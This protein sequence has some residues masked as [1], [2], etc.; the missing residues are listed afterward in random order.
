[1]ALAVGCG[2]TFGP[3]IVPP[4]GVTLHTMAID[5]MENATMEP[6]LGATL[7]QR[8]KGQFLASGR[9]RIVNHNQKPEALLTGRIVSLTQ[10]PVAFD[11]DSRAIEYRLEIHV[12]L[13]L[14]RRA[15]EAE[16]WSASGLLGYA[17][18][19]VNQD[20]ELS[21]ESKERALDDASQQIADAVTQ[22]FRPSLFETASPP[23]PPTTPPPTAPI[24]APAPSPASPPKSPPASK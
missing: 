13:A 16:L 1:M 17:D 10:T 20:V 19:Y 18:Y 4:L 5:L 24:T 6:Q 15:D 11:A 22:Q 14:T 9:W 7:T 21:R 12:D 3:A 8:L 23:A 2:Y